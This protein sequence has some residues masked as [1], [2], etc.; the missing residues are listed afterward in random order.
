MSAGDQVVAGL[1]RLG[2]VLRAHGR[3]AADHRGLTPTQAQILVFLHARGPA[4]VGDVAAMLAV[5]QPTASDAVAAL[6]RKGLVRRGADPDDA[7]AALLQP[8]AA[9]RTL[10]GELAGWPDAPLAAVTALSE[11]E[12]A[13]LLRALT[14]M[15]RT[16][17]QRGEIPV[18]RLC[19][20]CRFFRPF[21]H[22][23]AA[24]PHHCAFVDA[25]FGESAL[26]IDCGDHEPAE[27]A[28]AETAWRSFAH[29]VP[30]G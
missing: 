18:Q 29:A 23:D 2:A 10:A 27:A 20:T 9:G 7:R 14:T 26:R 13:G 16:L 19:V 17:Q 28:E 25:A 1:A 30:A 22:D 5:T 15:I 4:R 6:L 11:S 3:R 24:A 8:T 12:R 21:V